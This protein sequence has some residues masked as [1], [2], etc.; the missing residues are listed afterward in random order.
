[1]S[2]SW[3]DTRDGQPVRIAYADSVSAPDYR[4]LDNPR[5]PRIVEDYRAGFAA[6]RALPERD[7]PRFNGHRRLR[8]R[9][10]RHVIVLRGVHGGFA[11]AGELEDGL[12][13]GL[14]RAAAHSRPRRLAEHLEAPA[15]A[16]HLFCR[17]SHI[18]H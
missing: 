18:R 7:R 15:A 11:I 5:Y 10:P 1:M 8:Q 12:H 6:I 2:W 9:H 14:A 3:T 4:L 17:C 16:R 13:L